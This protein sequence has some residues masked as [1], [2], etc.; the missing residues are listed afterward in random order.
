MVSDARRAATGAVVPVTVKERIF[1]GDAVTYEVTTRDGQNV[2][3]REPLARKSGQS[4]D[5]GMDAFMHIAPDQHRVY[6][7]G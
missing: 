1:L 4:L 5:P 7:A 2:I 3:I 6:A